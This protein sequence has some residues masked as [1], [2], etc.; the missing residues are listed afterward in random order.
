MNALLPTVPHQCKA[1]VF[2]GGISA[3]VAGMDRFYDN[4]SIQIAGLSLLSVAFAGGWWVCGILIN[5]H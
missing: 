2:R 4:S 3:A 5:N 1:I